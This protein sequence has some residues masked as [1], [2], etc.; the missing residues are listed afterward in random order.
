MRKERAYCG[1][2]HDSTGNKYFVL[3]ESTGN[4]WLRHSCRRSKR[5][6][7]PICIIRRITALQHFRA[8][9][10]TWSNSL[11]AADLATQLS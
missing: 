10:E 1:T 5:H 7:D 11:K 4:P 9:S 3:T 6:V 2:M 8:T